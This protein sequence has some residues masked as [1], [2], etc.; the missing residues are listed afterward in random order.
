MELNSFLT[1]PIPIG[2][3]CPM[4]FSIQIAQAPRSLRARCDIYGVKPEPKFRFLYSLCVFRE[5][6]IYEEHP[7][8]PHLGDW[9]RSWRRRP[10]TR[11][12]RNN[13]NTAK[14]LVLKLI[15]RMTA[16]VVTLRRTLPRQTLVPTAMM[17]QAGPERQ[18]LLR[19]KFRFY[20]RRVSLFC[21][22]R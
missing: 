3:R 21:A 1:A 18:H 16:L 14:Q 12:A 7:Y 20:E 9:Y 5:A 6:A 22:S 17:G 10:V 15:L 11:L 2:H 4:P 8:A 13:A 19:G